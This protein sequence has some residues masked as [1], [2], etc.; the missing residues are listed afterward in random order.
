[1]INRPSR[2]AFTWVSEPARTSVVTVDCERVSDTRT[3]VILSHEKLPS[4]QTS[5]RHRDEWGRILEAL[6]G[7][8]A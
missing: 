6:A 4:Q 5:D 1:M 8:L 3:R 2:L 7:A